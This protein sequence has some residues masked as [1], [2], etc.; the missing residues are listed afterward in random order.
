MDRK[1][2]EEIQKG[3]AACSV[4]LEDGTTIRKNCINCPYQDP[5][6]P[7]GINCGERLMHDA[8][9]LIDELKGAKA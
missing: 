4:W 2:D 3:L 7:A 6:D 8:G 9:V 5:A 1:T